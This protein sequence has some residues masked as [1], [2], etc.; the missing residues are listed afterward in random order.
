MALGI[1]VVLELHSMRRAGSSDTAAPASGETNAAS[2]RSRKRIQ[3]QA[4][5]RN[6]NSGAIGAG[7]STLDQDMFIDGN[8]H[9]L[10]ITACYENLFRV[11]QQ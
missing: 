1:A 7:F 8:I 10:L 6:S 11:L 5:A 4:A 9:R 2:S 3:Q